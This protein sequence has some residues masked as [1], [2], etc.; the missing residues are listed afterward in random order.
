MESILY[1][2]GKLVPFLYMFWNYRNL[3]R[4]FDNKQNQREEIYIR[5]IKV[6]LHSMFI[7]QLYIF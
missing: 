3:V 7:M 1:T 2:E 6:A 5:K 4:M